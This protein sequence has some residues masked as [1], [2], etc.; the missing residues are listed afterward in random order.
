MP[1]LFAAAATARVL[2]EYALVYLTGGNGHFQ[3]ESSEKFQ[4]KGGDLF[5]LFPGIAH[6]YG[7]DPQ[8]GWDETWIIFQGYFADQ[9]RKQGVLDTHYP[10]LSI[11]LDPELTI[12]L[13]DMLNLASRQESG[14]DVRLAAKLYAFLT[15]IYARQK[16]S[17]C[18]ERCCGELAIRRACEIL[19][20]RLDSNIDMRKLARRC[21]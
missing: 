21:T 18:Y 12:V 9:L 11:G 3:S 15:D 10:L 17:I 1:A 20:P 13:D 5:F 2:N 7:P 19:A 4:I 8:T 14:V 16:G 6:T